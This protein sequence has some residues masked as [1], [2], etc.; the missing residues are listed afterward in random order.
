LLMKKFHNFG[1]FIILVSLSGPVSAQP[2]LV[3][4][5]VLENV[6]SATD[7]RLA[8]SLTDAMGQV[9]AVPA[10]AAPSR[11]EA[12]SEARDGYFPLRE[13]AVFL[14]EYTSSEFTGVK[15]VRLEYINYSGKDNAGSVS[16]TITYKGV[17]R[18]EVYGVHADAEGVYA[19]GGV[20]GG[21]R[22]EFPLPPAIGKNWSENS[23]IAN[24]AATDARV[25][26]P[27]GTFMNCLK[28]TAAIGGDAGKGERYYAPGIG[29]VYEQVRTGAGQAAVKL[30]SYQ[31]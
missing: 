7:G 26:V 2:D 12:A 28:V 22:M 15:L 14:Y 27:A 24:V 19:T 13:K 1:A 17:S 23:H 25:D 18:N 30:L 6:V 10:P 9:Q 20:I 11:E 5:A 16:K 4:K 3:N 8:A 21:R 29:L 31:D